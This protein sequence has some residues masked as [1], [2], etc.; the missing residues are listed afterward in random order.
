MLMCVFESTFLLTVWL[1]AIAVYPTAI[2]SV[3][4]I[5]LDGRTRTMNEQVHASFE[6]RKLRRRVTKSI[7]DRRL[8]AFRRLFA[9]VD[10]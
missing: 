9:I 4:V 1:K 7:V 8:L 5:E 2:L 3:V 6:D 10:A